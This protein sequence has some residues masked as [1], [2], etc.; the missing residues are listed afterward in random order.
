MEHGFEIVHFL[1][2][3]ALAVDWPSGA[4]AGY[5]IALEILDIATRP[6]SEEIPGA[7]IFA[8]VVE[9]KPAIGS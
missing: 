9:A 8:H 7:V 3:R 1:V 6:A 5:V 4:V 2:Q